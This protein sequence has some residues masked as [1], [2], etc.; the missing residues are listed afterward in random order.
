MVSTV[1]PTAQSLK[2]IGQSQVGLGM[3]MWPGTEMWISHRARGVMSL[4]KVM[5]ND[6]VIRQAGLGQELRAAR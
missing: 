4:D 6:L 3:G 5:N 1:K 2:P